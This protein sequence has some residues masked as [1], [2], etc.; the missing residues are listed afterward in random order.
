M[1]INASILRKLATL[2]LNSDQVAG[3]LDIIAS[4]SEEEEARKLAQRERTRRAREKQ[5]NATVTLQDCDSARYDTHGGMTPVDDKSLTS[6][7]EPQVKKDTPRAALAAVLDAERASAVIEHRSRIRKPLTGH[8]AKLLAGK[9]AQC[10]DPNAAAD[11]MVGN[12]WQGFEPEWVNR[13]N[14]RGSPAADRPLTAQQILKA[15]RESF[16][17]D[18]PA[19]DRPYLIV[20]R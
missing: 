10:P 16:R 18:E 13:P 8:A 6:E 11:M 2:Q 17:H 7:I 4:M 14:A 1:T 9:F 3:V 5:R 20:A 15:Q 19:P 12:G